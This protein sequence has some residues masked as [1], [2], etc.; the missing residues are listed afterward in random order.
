MPG[1]S[2]QFKQYITNDLLDEKRQIA[3]APADAVIEQLVAENG[4]AVAKEIFDTLISNIELPVEE[5]P[6][7][8]Q[9]F[10][11]EHSKLPTWADREQ[12]KLA[13]DLFVD[14]GP[15][16]LIFLFFKSLPILY[17]CANGAKV[18]VQTG[19]L[20]SEEGRAQFSR[21]IAE[22]GQFL[23]DVLAP[24]SILNSSHGIEAA[25][26]IR[27]IHASIRKFIPQERWDV[28]KLGKPINQ[29]DLAITLMT[30]SISILDALEQVGI[31]ESNEKKEAYLHTWKV[32]GNALGI[33]NDLFPPTL[34]N[35]RF[36]LNKIMQRQHRKS[37]AGKI[38]ADSLVNFSSDTFQTD[39]FKNTPH[40]LLRNF[41]GDEIA[42]LLEV[43]APLGCLFSWMPDALKSFFQL[44][45]RL[46]DRSESIKLI[47][48]TMS[49]ELTRRMVNYFNEAKNTHFQI[50]ENLKS[51]WFG[52]GL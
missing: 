7:I 16:F 6:E 4:S 31:G 48:D 50:P 38:L 46:E 43:K 39:F 22:T 15:K 44:E 47:I 33:Q 10:V 20:S 24:G 36:L 25:L 23:I 17:A 40:V 35:A 29:E 26:K 11:K 3:D 21:R 51:V 49:K 45:E 12:I 1:I 42:D 19:R 9:L 34:D 13:N 28:K 8:V 30:F 5:L 2:D 37:A 14:H 32:V 27:L 52:D 18:L 41:S